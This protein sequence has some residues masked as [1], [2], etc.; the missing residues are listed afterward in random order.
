M[1]QRLAGISALL[2]WA[3]GVGVTV[4]GDRMLSPYELLIL[5]ILPAIAISTVAPRRLVFGVVAM[6]ICAISYVNSLDR[7]IS[8]IYLF[9]YALII[10][11]H[12]LLF[13]EIFENDQAARVFLVAFVKTGVWLGPIAVV[14]FLSPIQI[15]LI[16]NTNFSLQYSLHRAQLFAPEASILA[17]LYILAICLA[18]YNSYTRIEPRMP[19]NLWSFLSLSM[20]LATTI[21]TSAFVV[22]P[23]LLLLIFRLSGVSW[24]R[25]MRYMV[26]GSIVLALFYLI[27]YQDR[28]SSGDSTNSSLVRIAS[29]VAGIRVIFQ[30]WTTGLGLG[31]NKTVAD[32]I[33]LIYVAWTH[34]LIK[35]PGIDSFQISLMAEMGVLPGL[36]SL[37]LLTVCYRTVKAKV[38]ATT[39]ATRLVAMLSICVWFISLLTSGY[40]GLV[41]CWLF[42]PAGYVVYLQARPRVTQTLTVEGTIPHE[43]R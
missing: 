12:M 36:F 26:L 42:F 7:S 10:I 21:S 37:I 23:P 3:P 5:L 29:I 24:K 39:S 20:G 4:Y 14:Q 1:L 31:M 13:V 34:D 22:L 32:A 15:T 40:R 11:P 27:E 38:S 19:G 41:Y 9:Y 43:S 18:I 8:A 6:G 33:A 2:L 30:H 25:L 17:A 35:K 16:N 28:V